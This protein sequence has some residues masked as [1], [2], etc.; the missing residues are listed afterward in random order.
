MIILFDIVIAKVT[1]EV[2]FEE[3]MAV[4]KTW[5]DIF[6]NYK[7]YLKIRTSANFLFA[8]AWCLEQWT[9]IQYKFW[10]VL[11]FFMAAY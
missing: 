4:S 11:N 7:K 8:F 3:D 10:N 6:D 5:L 2:I 9:W 1:S